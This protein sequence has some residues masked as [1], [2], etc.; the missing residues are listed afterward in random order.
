MIDALLHPSLAV[1]GFDE[2]LEEGVGTTRSCCGQHLN[3]DRSQSRA[4]RAEE[5]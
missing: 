1:F 4:E 3:L 2:V 5:K